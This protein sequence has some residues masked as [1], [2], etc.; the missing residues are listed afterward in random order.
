MQTGLAEAWQSRV[1][2]QPAE[3]IDRLA[4]ES[5]LANALLHQGKDAHAERVLRA[6]HEVQMRVL[7]A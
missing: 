4:A 1:A 5:Q 6:L 7:R 3:I 2:G